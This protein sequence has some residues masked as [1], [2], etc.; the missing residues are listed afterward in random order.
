MTRGCP[1]RFEVAAISDGR[2]LGIER[3]DFQR[4]LAGCLDCSHEARALGALDAAVRALPAPA[5][6]VLHVRRER[7]RLLAAFDRE[8]V[9]TERR[10]KPMHWLWAPAIVALLLLWQLRSASP[11]PVG[12][13]LVHASSS[14]VWSMR[15][16]GQLDQLRLERGS[17][18]IQIDHSRAITRRLIVLLPDGELEDI[19]TK[20]TVSVENARTTHVAVQE[21]S[22]EL[23]VR[24]RPA[25]ILATGETWIPAP[26]PP[27]A[28]SCATKP[29]TAIKPVTA[30]EPAP[31]IEPGPTIEPAPA[32]SR[33]RL[34]PPTTS[35]R[36]FRDAVALLQA[37]DNMAA[38]R[39]FAS[40]A[41][42]YP[43][44]LR[45][46]DA[47][48][49]RVIA[50]QRKGDE[51]GMKHAARVYLQRHPAGFRRTEM[52]SASR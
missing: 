15:T 4:H 13:P 41:A 22:V 38:A 48:Y 51:A 25:V 31:A 26:P 1:R 46:E 30:V 12:K 44:D 28:A 21:G 20:F 19:G 14:A 5:V 47:A 32:Q 33:A 50:L 37:G 9:T 35:A 36:A 40:F 2:V 45:A 16:Q 7:T 23:R 17:L 10:S 6:N 27:T 29:A 52:E 39:A 43:R 18:S 11:E 3:E 34:R 8:L 24:G 49:L 42:N